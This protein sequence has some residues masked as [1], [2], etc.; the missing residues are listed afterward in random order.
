MKN[1]SI[2]SM[3]TM[4]IKVNE[5]QSKRDEYNKIIRFLGKYI[6]YYA[7]KNKKLV[8]DL[9]LKFINYGKTELVYVLTDNDK[10]RITL[11]VKQLAVKLGDVYQEMQNLLELNEKDSHVIAPIDYF[12]LG[13]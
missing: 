13:D 4:Y 10:K 5:I 3:N 2:G 12:Q 8:E 6:E 11:L 7:E 1:I 9:K